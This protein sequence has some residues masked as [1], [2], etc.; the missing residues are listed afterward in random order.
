MRVYFYLFIFCLISSNVSA[1]QVEQVTVGVN[2]LHCS[3][4]SF[5]VEKA[6][7]KVNFVSVVM[8]DLNE[9]E[10]RIIL[11]ED[12]EIDYHKLAK[13]VTDAGYSVRNVKITLNE[14]VE[15][16]TSCLSIASS[17]FCLLDASNGGH[18]LQLIDKGFI[19]KKEYKKIQATQNAS[20]EACTED[21]NTY[22]ALWN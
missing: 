11:D 2:G 13:A 3:A 21:K 19:P 15:E 10:A 7:M 18:T 20:C 16:P 9:R 5:T 22:L 12:K 6:L 4:C 17:Q 14:K 1:Q 8:M